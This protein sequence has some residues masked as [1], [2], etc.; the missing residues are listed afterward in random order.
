MGPKRSHLVAPL[1]VS[2]MKG[3]AASMRKLAA[4]IGTVNFLTNP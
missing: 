1:F 3:T 4:N 2:P